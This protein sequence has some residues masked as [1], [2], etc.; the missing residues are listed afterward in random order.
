MRDRDP[1]CAKILATRKL[2]IKVADACGI[3]PAAVYQWRR[4]PPARVLDVAAVLGLTPEQ[5]R[6]DIFRS[7]SERE[8]HGKTR[9]ASRRDQR[10]DC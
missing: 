1:I 9:K 8:S 2:S 4:V 10:Q 5:I 6:P 7:K 3:R